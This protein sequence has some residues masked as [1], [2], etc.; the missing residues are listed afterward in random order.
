M[1]G[2]E[3][4]F[5]FKQ[6]FGAHFMRTHGSAIR[7]AMAALA[8]GALLLANPCAKSAP[9][10]RITIDDDWRFQKGDP[11]GNLV[12]LAYDSR[13]AEGPAPAGESPTDASNKPAVA[14]AAAVPGIREW[15][16][17]TGDRFIAD[18][19]R[20]FV[21]PK[22]NFGASVPYVQPGYDDSAWQQVNLPPKA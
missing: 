15:I 9:R 22:E 21:R 13:L 5:S 19:S 12:N 18:A 16:L 6:P 14:T 17:P 2:R 1:M 7:T 4:S 10:E 8:I 3:K 20:R 11:A